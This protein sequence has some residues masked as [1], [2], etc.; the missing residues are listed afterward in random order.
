MYSLLRNKYDESHGIKDGFNSSHAYSVALD[1]LYGAWLKANY[2]LEY[3]AVVLNIYKDSKDKQAGLI[4]ELDY[5]GISLKG[6][7][8]G[9]SKS[10]YSYEKETNTIY[11]GISTVAYLNQQVA[12][13]LY[14]LAKEKHYEKDDVIQL[15]LDILDGALA[16]NRQMN[17]LIKLGFFKEFG[18]ESIL[19]ELYNTMTGYQTKK[20]N[21]IFTDNKKLDVKYSRTHK[22]KTKLVRIENIKEY[23]GL[24]LK[25]AHLLPTTNLFDRLTSEVEYMGYAETLDQ[26]LGKNVY[27]VMDVNTK[28][29]P[30]YTLYNMYDG[31]I[32]VAKIDKKKAYRDTKSTKDGELI[33]KLGDQIEVQEFTQR[34]KMSLVDGKW[35]SNYDQ[36]QDYIEHVRMI[37]RYK[38]FL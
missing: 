17:I 30:V 31:H 33:I 28:Y 23:Y 36:M 5:F 15:F 22:E 9:K 26:S 8:F 13:N 25:N 24:I 32:S 14:N 20:P 10:D 12:D 18:E 19:L 21:P 27:V 16:D 11:K 37:E 1:S 29:T 4:N 38:D 7:Q 2:P 3:F 6:L 34:P 35:E